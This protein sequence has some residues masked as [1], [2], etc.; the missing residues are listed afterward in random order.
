MRAATTGFKKPGWNGIM[1][2]K[3]LVSRASSAEMAHGSSVMGKDGIN[4]PWK[5]DSSAARAIS[6]R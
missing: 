2:R 6:A 3:V 5:P 4:P 1:K